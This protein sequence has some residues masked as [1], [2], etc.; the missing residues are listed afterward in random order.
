MLFGDL[1]ISMTKYPINHKDHKDITQ[2]YTKELKQYIS[3]QH[4]SVTN[5]FAGTCIS[6]NHCCSVKF[7][8]LR[9]TV[10][11]VPAL[12]FH[13]CPKLNEAGSLMVRFRLPDLIMETYILAASFN[14]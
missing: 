10:F 2:M 7:N 4:P 6:F 13:P 9:L 11:P 1:I 5:P 8:R 14:R 3:K 12:Q